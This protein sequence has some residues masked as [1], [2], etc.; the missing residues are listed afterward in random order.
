MSLRCP[1]NNPLPTYN[2]LLFKSLWTELDFMPTLSHREAGK[3]GL[4]IEMTGLGLSR[5][6][7]WNWTQKLG[8]S[9][10]GAWQPT[11]CAHG[12]LLKLK[13]QLPNRDQERAR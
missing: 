5:S 13:G 9:A 11:V 4:N 1:R 12:H 2:T 10:R 8:L 3:M 6:I 7:T